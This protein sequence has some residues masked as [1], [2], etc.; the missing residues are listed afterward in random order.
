MWGALQL[1]HT[2]KQPAPSPTPLQGSALAKPGAV[3]AFRCQ[4]PRKNAFYG[5]EPPG[6]QDAAPQELPVRRRGGQARVY[7]A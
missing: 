2:H 1:L 5:Y 6:P 7:E 3:L 4:L